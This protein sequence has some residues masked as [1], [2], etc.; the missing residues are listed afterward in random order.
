MNHMVEYESQWLK[1]I[2]DEITEYSLDA[3]HSGKDKVPFKKHTK[4][5][6]TDS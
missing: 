6:E 2:N 1:V 4:I 3:C 5:M